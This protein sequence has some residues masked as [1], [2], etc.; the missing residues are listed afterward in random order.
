MDKSERAV[1]WSRT[2]V[3]A[4]SEWSQ[5]VRT[6]VGLVL[7]NPETATSA[8]DPAL[9]PEE[10]VGLRILIVDDNED[11]ANLL[12]ELLRMK[13]HDV[14][15]AHDGIAALQARKKFVPDVA[16]LDIGL[17]GM[18]GYDLARQLRA[19]YPSDPLRIIAITGYGEERDRMRSKAA[20]FDEHLVK[21]VDMKRVSLLLTACARE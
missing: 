4:V 1:D 3:G 10:A 9:A 15:V 12:A 6:M 13:G 20:G 2:P 14:V 7:R 19:L 21:P 8:P 11:A 17:P 16:L 5:T 18:D